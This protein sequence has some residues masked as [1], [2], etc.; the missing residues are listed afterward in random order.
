MTPCRYYVRWP[1]PSQRPERIRADLS[2]DKRHHGGIRSQ[3]VLRSRRDGTGT[4]DWWTFS[5]RNESVLRDHLAQI[6][7][8]STPPP[9]EQWDRKHGPT[10]EAKDRWQAA[11]LLFADGV[12][13]QRLYGS[14]IQAEAAWT[15]AGAR[16]LAQILPEE[17]WD[18]RQNIEQLCSL[19]RVRSRV[20]R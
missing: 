7:A 20:C 14:D 6:D 16:Q 8:H 4:E 1:Y 3:L 17:L 15:A 18:L 13:S 10:I 12:Y 5:G 19:R 2:T 11:V 9:V